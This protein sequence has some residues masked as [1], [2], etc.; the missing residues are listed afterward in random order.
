MTV[1]LPAQEKATLVLLSLD[2][3]QF[4]NP[5][6]Q[7]EFIQQFGPRTQKKQLGQEEDYRTA[8]FFEGLI[9]LM[10]AFFQL[11]SEPGTKKP[12]MSQSEKKFFSISCWLSI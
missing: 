8:H 1:F 3:E 12:S 7:L 11:P 10:D 5:V 2:E 9:M 4:L 6:K